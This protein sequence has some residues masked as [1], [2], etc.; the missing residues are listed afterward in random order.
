VP[1]S[2]TDIQT[3]LDRTMSGGSKMSPGLNTRLRVALRRRALDSALADGVDPGG[4]PTL[5]FR[6]AQLTSHRNRETLSASIARVLAEVRRPRSAGWSAAVP[7]NIE[8]VAAS[9]SLLTQI[10][11]MLQSDRPVYCQ[12]M[13]M[14]ECLLTDGASPLYG[15][16]G[17]GG[18]SDQLERVIAVLEGGN[19][20]RSWPSSNN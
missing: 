6:A 2:V 15:R 18:L 13:A 4:S 12:G 14:L 9:W 19:G 20:S 10:E 11:A 3:V 7:L 1:P 17:K 16:C 5:E 8:E